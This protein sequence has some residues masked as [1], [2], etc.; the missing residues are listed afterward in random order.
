ME[1][2]PVVV[3]GSKCSYDP[4]ATKGQATPCGRVLDIL[5]E[6]GIAYTT[7][8]SAAA[9]T[10][11]VKIGPALVDVND[12]A[13]LDAALSAASYKTAKTTPNFS[14]TVQVI[15]AIVV[16]GLASG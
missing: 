8:E 14:Q 1:R 12:P 9:A 5:S 16:I 11:Q 15:F 7:V 13:A 10:P 6:R 4:F 3:T 2:N